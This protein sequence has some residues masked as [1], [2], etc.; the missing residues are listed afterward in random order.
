[1]RKPWMKELQSMRFT[2]DGTMTTET[3]RW[4]KEAN[5]KA[6]H[7]VW[8]SRQI[9]KLPEHLRRKSLSEQWAMN[10]QSCGF[11]TYGQM[12]EAE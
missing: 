2:R 1:M 6:A 5:T 7:C 4:Q 12:M 10:L 9:D 3:A 8:L 11:T